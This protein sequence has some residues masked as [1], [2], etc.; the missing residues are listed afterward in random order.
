M[1]DNPLET[2]CI[3]VDIVLFASYR[4]Q[5]GVKHVQLELPASAH[6]RHA[7]EMLEARY[8]GLSLRGGLCAINAHYVNPDATLSSG[9]TLA[10]F[11]PVSGG[12]GDAD[13]QAQPSAAESSPESIPERCPDHFIVSEAALTI[14]D[15]YERLSDPRYGALA[16]FVGTVRSPNLGHSVHYIDYQGYESMMYSQMQRIASELRQRHQIGA[17]LIAHRLGRLY[18]G[19]ASIA[20]VVASVHRREA[21]LACQEAI[22]RVKA[23][24]PV[25]K[26]EVTDARAH[27][28][29]G[30]AEAAETL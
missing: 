23:L 25:W 5:A 3:T 11:P 28:V 7:A 13:S 19:E 9:D 24:L 21:L 6:V 22:E 2:A 8:S 14:G 4:E 17:V 20:I 1:N 29:A 16:S 30:N 15:Y 27:W 12:S 10:F 26:Y 18:P